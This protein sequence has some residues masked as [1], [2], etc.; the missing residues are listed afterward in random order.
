MC[1]IPQMHSRGH[2]VRTM[3]KNTTF[4][5]E[6]VREEWR[7]NGST[8]VDVMAV[9]QPWSKMCWDDASGEP[10]DPGAVPSERKLRIDYLRHLGVSRNVPAQKAQGGAFTILGGR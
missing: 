7:D 10:L 2:D 1:R 3:T 4:Q 8:T 9:T 6:Q 5:E